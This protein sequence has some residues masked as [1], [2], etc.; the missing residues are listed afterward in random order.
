MY[1]EV[2][3]L[4]KAKCRARDE[5]GVGLDP[6]RLFIATMRRAAKVRV[7][8]LEP[9]ALIPVAVLAVLLPAL[10][11]CATLRKAHVLPPRK[12]KAVAV[13][14][15]VPRRVGT[16]TLVNEAERFVLI[17]TGFSTVPPVGVALKSMSGEVATGVVVVGNVARRPFVVADIVQGAPKKGDGVFQ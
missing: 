4:V 13:A 6:A 10:A 14:A 17:D 3:A 15:A 7:M 12:A 9:R 1:G 16:I 2:F 5:S 8:N 11:G